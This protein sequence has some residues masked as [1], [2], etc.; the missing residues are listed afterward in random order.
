MSAE[1]AWELC[2]G[3]MAEFIDVPFE[4]FKKRLADHRRQ[5]KRGIAQAEKDAEALDC[6]RS[7]PCRS[8][9]VR[10]IQNCNS[11]FCYI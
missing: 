1:M 8:P 11:N 9:T 5:M 6:G 10:T 7:Q 2:Y 3:N 4:Q